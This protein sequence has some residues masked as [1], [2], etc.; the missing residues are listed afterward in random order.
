VIQ[1]NSD[2]ARQLTVKS[3]TINVKTLPTSSAG[4][5]SGDLWNNAGVVNIIP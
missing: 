1:R 3:N 2:P 5:V 4:L